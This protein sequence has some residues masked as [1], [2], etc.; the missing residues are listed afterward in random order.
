MCWHKFIFTRRM[1]CERWR[2]ANQG[3]YALARADWENAM[4]YGKGHADSAELRL[5]RAMALACGGRLDEAGRL[6]DQVC[7]RPRNQSGTSIQLRIAFM[8]ESSPLPPIDR[9]RVAAGVLSPEALTARAV[10]SL[11]K[12]LSDQS[13][14]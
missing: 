14:A 10:A 9:N 1:S 6:A 12:H 11:R 7:R 3:K 13:F 2:K 4:D 8:R 5:R